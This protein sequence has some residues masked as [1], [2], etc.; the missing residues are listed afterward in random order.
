LTVDGQEF[1]LTEE[2]LEVR[3]LQKEGVAT[4]GDRDL[5]VALDVHLTPELIA[6]GRA[7]EIVSRIQAARKDADLDYA[8]RIFVRFTA[9]SELV[10]AIEA[11]RD[12]IAGETLAT[13]IEVATDAS[14]LTPAPIDDLEFSFSVE[15]V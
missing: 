14:G 13:R 6:E 11:H 15:K 3:L 8:D 2:D 9:A 4:A 10:A 1:R 5:L 12:W 7:R